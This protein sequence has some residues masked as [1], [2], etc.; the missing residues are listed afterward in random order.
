MKRPNIVLTA[1]LASGPLLF[2]PADAQAGWS[3]PPNPTLN[4]TTTANDFILR[5]ETV[6]F[7]GADYCSNAWHYSGGPIVSV[8]CGHTVF[9]GIWEPSPSDVGGTWSQSVTL[10]STPGGFHA[11]TSNVGLV[12]G[13]F[14][15]GCNSGNGELYAYDLDEGTLITGASVNPLACLILVGGI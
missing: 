5:S 8:A 9:I 7:S 11:V 14:D 3:T 4:V 1:L 13:S 12:S 6:S 10:Q 2:L 15:V